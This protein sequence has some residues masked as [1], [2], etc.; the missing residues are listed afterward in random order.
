V[1][2]ERRP[3]LYYIHTIPGIEGV[4]RDE[5]ATLLG[6]FVLEGFKTVPDRNGM[7]VFSTTEDARR[8]MDLRLA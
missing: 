8:L 7:V 4:A 1:P 3:T 2:S 5:L 6:V